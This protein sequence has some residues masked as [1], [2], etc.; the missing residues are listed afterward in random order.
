[1]HS[2]LFRIGNFELHTWGLALVLSIV[3]G[4][5]VAS[6]RAKKFGIETSQILDLA[7]VIMVAAI[8]GS[9]LWYVLFHLDEFRGNWFD[10]INPVHDDYF[11]IA[12]LSMVG[13]VV[14]AVIAAFIYT[15]VRKLN[16]LEIGDTVAPSFLLGAGIQRVGGCFMAGCCFGK[17]TDCG[18]GVVFP[19]GSVAGSIFPGQAL[20]PAQ[21]LASLLGFLGFVLVLWLGRWHR[22]KGYTMWMV[23][24]YYAVDRF[25]VDQFRYYEP[26]QIMGRLGPVVFNVNHL[27]LAAMFVVSAAFWIRGYLR[28]RLPA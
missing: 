1:M 12:G 19:P 11:G 23:F 20:Y 13:G 28:S 22:F 6:K 4:V 21:L 18:L 17:P 5:W 8:I 16:F 9:R 25:L 15:R 2:I 7:F 26:E 24:A 10:V 14:L 27:L 3:L